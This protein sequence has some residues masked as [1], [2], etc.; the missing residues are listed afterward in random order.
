VNQADATS[1]SQ[2]DRSLLTETFAALQEAARSVAGRARASQSGFRVGAAV[3]DESGRIHVGCN[4]ETAAHTAVH[5]EE[6]AVAA[7]AA[8]G[9]SPIVAICIS[10][11]HGDSIPPCG[12]CRQLLS[13]IAPDALVLF[14]DHRYLSHELLPGGFSAKDLES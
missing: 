6:A 7:W 5:A 11:P 9:E 1:R 14:G 4:V 2:G 10:G 12:M 13:E 3:L 8:H